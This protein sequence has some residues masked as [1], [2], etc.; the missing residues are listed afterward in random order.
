M[1]GR[2]QF[3]AAGNLYFFQQGPVTAGSA[4]PD[5]GGGTCL[6][7]N[8]FFSFPGTCTDAYAGKV[9]SSG[10]QVFG[11]YLGGSTNDQTTALAV[12]GS[13][14]V[15]ITGVTGGSFRTTT[16]AA[17][18]VSAS[19]TAFA[20]KLS[21]DGS[22]VVYS[23][24]LPDTAASPSAIAVDGQGN[25][26]VAGRSNSS[27]AFVLKLS[28]D[29][30]KIL[31]NVTLAG[32]QQDSAS[33]IAVDAAGNVSVAGQT[34]S[35]D[36]P[37]TT[38]ALQTRL[39]GAQN[40]FAARLDPAGRVVFATY[41][42]GSGTDTA[43]ALQ[44]DAAG[45]LYIAG[46]T[47]S[48]DFPT[49]AGS[50]ETAP[51][52]PLWNSAS[53]AGIVARLK[54]DGKGLDWSTYVMSMDHGS[55]QGIT[56]LAVTASGDAYIAGLT[57]AGFPVTVSAPDL[58]FQGMTSSVFVAHLD[59]KGA[60]ADATYAGGQNLQGPWA[61]SVAG[62][63]SVLLAM[64]TDAGN[65][66]SEIRFGAPGVKRNACLSPAVL[67]SATMSASRAVV[68]GELI[69][70]TGYGIGP[71]TGAAYQPDAQGRI[72]RELGGVQV[73]FDGE[74]AP[75]LYAQSRQIDVLAPVE[76]SKRTQTKIDVMFNQVSAGSITSQVAEYGSPGIFRLQP[77][78]SAQA[79]ALNQDGSL[80]SP[81]NPAARNSVVSVWGTGFGITDPPCTTGGINPPGAA[82][83][84]EGLSAIVA[85]SPMPGVPV[86][87]S[88]A[89]YAGSAP[90]LPCGVE[91]INILVPD[92]APTGA[93][94]FLPWSAMDLPGGAKSVAIDAIGATI[95]VR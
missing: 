27:H 32:S 36:F 41:L 88:P 39:K 11:T 21:A 1:L 69:A 68:P 76:L 85:Y 40:L 52:V 75:V 77:G 51:V 23:T 49:T 31:Y 30:S 14:N 61:L 12:D 70:L 8:G 67:N 58:C 62:D 20:A 3:D 56:K 82:N 84:A 86:L 78:A 43:A 59:S 29:G 35:P 73:L 63:N 13:G 83:L 34:A 90:A 16:N 17:L 10:K 94:P 66:K 15:Y 47:S 46:R 37:V 2:A 65:V 57:G 48:F 44:T 95:F 19:A 33:A 45:N 92:Y 28:S 60:V 80:N 5:T 42:G 25:A 64:L 18:A 72:P 74:P 91:Q 79:A 87:S 6:F 26:Y 22:R 7:S 89:V 24:Y 38:G 9:D 4:Q 55:E 81:S 54:A 50:F 53:A 71:D 93:F